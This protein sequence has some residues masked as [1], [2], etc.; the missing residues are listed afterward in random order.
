MDT[1]KR[2]HQEV[3]FK[4]IRNI[5][6]CLLQVVFFGIS[7]FLIGLFFQK[8]LFY[9]TGYIILFYVIFYS[10]I[11]FKINR[12]IFNSKYIRLIFSILTI[13]G[14]IFLT[15]YLNKNFNRLNMDYPDST[16]ERFEIIKK[17]QQDELKKKLSSVING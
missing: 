12:R 16:D 17:N 7:A 1:V 11:V 4:F 10:F 6:Y 15:L 5:F 14:T 13:T 9:L 3:N 2:K 8:I